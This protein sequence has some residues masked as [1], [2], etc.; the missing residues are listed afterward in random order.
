MNQHHGVARTPIE[1]ALITSEIIE[2]LMP[3]YGDNYAIKISR[4]AWHIQTAQ[5]VYPKYNMT[6]DAWGRYIITTRDNTLIERGTL[7]QLRGNNTLA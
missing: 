5:I 3:T 1:L 4:S 6:V 2:H 7:N